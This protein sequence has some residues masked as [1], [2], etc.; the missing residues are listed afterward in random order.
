MND[1]MTVDWN[2]SDVASAPLCPPSFRFRTP[3]RASLKLYID[4]CSL[5]STFSLMRVT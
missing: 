1:V 5:F 4:Y 3:E 2:I